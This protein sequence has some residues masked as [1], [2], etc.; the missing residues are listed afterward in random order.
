MRLSG[1]FIWWKRK[2]RNKNQC[3]P[4]LALETRRGGYTAQPG[5]QEASILRQGDRGREKAGE[6]HRA[7]RRPE[8]DA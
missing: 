8:A 1:C 7:R 3:A 5:Y 2:F 4:W 6:A